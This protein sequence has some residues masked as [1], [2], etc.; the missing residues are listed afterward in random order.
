MVLLL[1][2]CIMEFRERVILRLF[3]LPVEIPYSN[4][5]RLLEEWTLQ[6]KRHGVPSHK[7]VSWIR[8]KIG[9]H[10]A[11]IRY[12]SDG[13]LG[14]AVPCIFCQK[15]L[16]KYDM[17]IHCPT[18]S[19]GWFSGRLTDENAPKPVLTAGQRRM[20]KRDIKRPP[21]TQTPS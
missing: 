6:A 21:G 7:I 15:E 3:C 16:L 18:A 20:F 4:S 9:T 11:I 17:H 10:I 19:G 1:F 5:C 8:R 13:T 14:C 12:R 2:K